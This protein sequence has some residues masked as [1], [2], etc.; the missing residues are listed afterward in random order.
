M[1]EKL[2]EMIAA[3]KVGQP[4][5]TGVGL[6]GDGGLSDDEPDDDGATLSLAKLLKRARA[7]KEMAHDPIRDGDGDGPSAKKRR[8]VAFR[9]LVL[10]EWAVYKKQ[11]PLSDRK[12]A[13]LGGP[14]GWW[15]QNQDTFPHVAELARKYLAVQASSA[16]SEHLFSTSGNTI[17]AKRK[18]LSGDRA[19]DILFLHECSKL[20]LW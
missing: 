19:S 4:A 8:K 20:E 10:S 11:K 5:D 14:L 17:T 13:S 9:E 15:A 12:L 2:E 1:E 3:R 7:K 18:R 6:S 16:S